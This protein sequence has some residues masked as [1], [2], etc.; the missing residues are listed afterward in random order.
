MALV[1]VSIIVD[2]R[3][4]YSFPTKCTEI[5]SISNSD[6]PKLR[7]NV[8]EQVL[9]TNHLFQSVTSS[10]NTGTT[11]QHLQNGKS[12]YETIIAPCF[13]SLPDSNSEIQTTDKHMGQLRSLNAIFGRRKARRTLLQYK[14]C[15][16]Q[17][18]AY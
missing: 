3:K 18:T 7:I 6:Q 10:Y 15:F 1:I 14:R 17:K 9:G 5:H 11:N 2:C 16:F 13:L 4:H 12:K 8:N